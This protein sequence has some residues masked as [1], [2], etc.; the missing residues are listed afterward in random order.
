MDVQPFAWFTNDLRG[1]ILAWVDAI[2]IW[3]FGAM[4]GGSNEAE[5]DGQR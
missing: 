1:I 3:I 4:C 5:R 2:N